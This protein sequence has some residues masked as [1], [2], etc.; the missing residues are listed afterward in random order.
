MYMLVLAG[1]AG[2]ESAEPV[3]VRSAPW[4]VS[5]AFQRRKS[6][7]IPGPG[8]HGAQILD[9]IDPTAESRRAGNQ[10]QMPRGKMLPGDPA[11]QVAGAAM[12]QN[13]VNGPGG[14]GNRPR[15]H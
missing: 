11:G 7:S 6:P 4:P 8:A 9:H 1:A 10:M 13:M 2:L 15:R 14:D 5:V 3:I 12:T